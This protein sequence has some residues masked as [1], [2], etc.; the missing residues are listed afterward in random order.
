MP[1]PFLHGTVFIT[2]LVILM[3]EVLGSR[4]MGPFFGISLYIWASLISVTLIAL[5]LGYW[6]GGTMADRKSKPSF[7]YSIILC[8]AIAILLI[9]FISAPVME[10]SYNLLGIRGGVLLSALLIFS[11]PLILLGMA[12]PYVIRLLVKESGSVGRV[13]GSVFAISTMGSVIG[14]LLTA[15]VLIPNLGVN[16]SFTLGALLLLFLFG[17]YTIARKKYYQVLITLLIIAISLFLLLFYHRT[18][19]KDDLRQIIYQTDTL[20]GQLKVV[21]ILNQDLRAALI[22]GA[23]QSLVHRSASYD[24]AAMYYVKLIIQLLP[25]HQKGGGDALIIGLGAGE[26]PRFISK[27]GYRSDIIEIDPRVEMMAKNYFNFTSEFGRVIIDDGRRYIRSC[28]K[29]YD[30]IFVDV[31]SGGTQPWYF[32]T[33]EAFQEMA[34]ILRPDGIIG[35]NLIGYYQGE[36]SKAAQSINRTLMTAYRYS[37]IY[38][39][40]NPDPSRLINIIFFVSNKPFPEN[41]EREK[42]LENLNSMTINFNPQ[43]G[44]ILTDNYNPLDLWSI[45]VSEAFRKAMFGWLGKKILR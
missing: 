25:T 41:S 16:K 31:A 6:L 20:Y 27:I 35:I 14:A 28:T 29:K 24:A 5:S 12:S 22:D 33:K 26:I 38:I 43:D 8:S 2:G 11:V 9:Q 32:F 21:D 39:P 3:L 45:A 13:A 34:K 40:T 15:F 19:A 42:I 10:W 44:I 37:K 7:L 18:L 36:N 4:V 23:L 30:L 17:V 1:I